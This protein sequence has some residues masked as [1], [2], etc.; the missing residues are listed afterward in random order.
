MRWQLAVCT[1][2]IISGCRAEPRATQDMR[3]A[4][5]DLRRQY[6]SAAVELDPTAQVA[7]SIDLGPPR[8]P[9]PVQD[10]TQFAMQFVEQRE[11]L[12]TGSQSSFE[13]R[14]RGPEEPDPQVPG[15][16]IVRLTQFVNGVEVFGGEIVAHVRTGTG[17]DA[18]AMTVSNS[19]PPSADVGGTPAI[20]ADTATSAAIAEHKEYTSRLPPAEREAQQVAPAMPRLVIFDPARFGLD[21]ASKLAWLVDIGS[22]RIF[23]DAGSGGIVRAYRNAPDAL[24]R[25]VYECN[26]SPCTVAFDGDKQVRQTVSRDAAGL[27][28]S[29]RDVYDYFLKVHARDGFDDAG[30]GGRARTESYALS[31][32]V[33]NAQYDP[34]AKQL[35]FAP[36]WAARDIF[37]HEFTHALMYHRPRV[38]YVGQA[39][40]VQEFYADLFAA[41]FEDE[42]PARWIIGESVPGLPPQRRFLRDL[43]NPHADGFN[44]AQWPDP[45]KNNGQP[46]HMTELVRETDKICAALD[47]KERG[48]VHF[49]GAILS[50]AA[51]L[52][53]DGGTH[54]GVAVTGIGV[55]KFQYTAYVAMVSLKASPLLADVATG[56]IAACR[57]A[58]VPPRLGMT[59]ADCDTIV[60]SLKSVGLP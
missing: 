10:P 16:S 39:G 37:A 3:A 54:R 13:V 14:P 27:F 8:A 51:A 58:L 50:K 41:L 40:A 7:R 11:R 42:S 12:F 47:E 20:S 59:A 34:G 9:S 1:V 22:R 6:P 30:R 45:A 57:G 4:I 33:P 15:G 23:V 56:L 17:A 35:K 25:R 36:G 31:T 28:M 38:E 53:A 29:S 19:P 43:R 24:L 5:E 2:V 60:Q 44:R 18:G 32:T 48:C 26:V 21:G 49:N 55:E 46:D 52:A